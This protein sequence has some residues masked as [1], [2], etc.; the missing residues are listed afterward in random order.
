[1]IE[2]WNIS[3]FKLGCDLKVDAENESFHNASKLGLVSTTSVGRSIRRFFYDFWLLLAL[4]N[5]KSEKLINKQ[6]ILPLTLV[7]EQA[8]TLSTCFFRFHF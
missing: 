5:K 1:M 7:V 2:N 3:T 6:R 8:L 4:K